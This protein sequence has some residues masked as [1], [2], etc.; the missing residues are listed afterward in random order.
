MDKVQP[1][2]KLRKMS[3]AVFD[4]LEEMKKIKPII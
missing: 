4:S 3:I 2:D 1:T